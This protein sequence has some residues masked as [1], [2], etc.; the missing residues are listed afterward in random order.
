MQNGSARKAEHAAAMPAATPAG[1]EPLA[2]LRERFLRDGYLVVRGA[3][4]QD[5]C[6]KAVAAFEG[7]VKP[8]RSYFLRHEFGT[9]D[10]HVFTEH[11]YMKYPIMNV[12][13][14]SRT[15]FGSFV[16]HGL[17]VL[18]SRRIREVMAALLGEEGRMVHTMF[19]DGNQQTWAH[20]DSHYIDSER[21]GSMIGVWVAAED[22]DPGAGRFFVYA[23]SHRVATPPELGLDRIDPNSRAYKDAMAD[24]AKRSGCELVAPELKRGDMILWS[25]L[26]VHGSLPTTE[27]RCSRKSFTAHYIPQSHG[28][29][30]GRHVRGAQREI[31]VNGV[32]I[33]RHADQ[34]SWA[35]QTKAAVRELLHARAPW[36]LAG[37]LALRR[38]ARRLASGTA[39]RPR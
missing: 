22:I 39:R 16:R 13:D 34:G 35:T 14:L 37:A 23:G 9:Y 29:L 7:E 18:T 8:S 20:R 26:T 25:S 19:F 5:L 3:V 11:G 6:R 12:Q 21:V 4:P 2:V 10:R 30:W 24:W 15:R 27:P 17:D 31:A 38:G 28:Y 33:A 36:L 1:P 32:R